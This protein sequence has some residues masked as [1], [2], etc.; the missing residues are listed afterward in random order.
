[1]R[2]AATGVAN[3]LRVVS[4]SGSR[5]TPAVLGGCHGVEY[6]LSSAMWPSVHTGSSCKNSA[7]AAAA[8]PAATPSHDRRL[9]SKSSSGKPTEA[10]DEAGSEPE[11]FL[12][13][14]ST[15]VNTL[16]SSE[17]SSP[18]MLTG[19][20]VKS[21]KGY[22]EREGM[23]RETQKAVREYYK[24]GMYQD[25]LEVTERLVDQVDDHFGRA[26]GV[27]G[28]ALSDM[29][30]MLKSVG[31]HQEATDTYL[32]AL[33]VYRAVYKGEENASFAS[34]LH[35]LGMLFRAMAEDSKKL[36]K[37]PLMERAAESFERCV[38][39]REKILTNN[40][41]DLQLARSRLAT[42]QGMLGGGEKEGTEARLR[43]ALD[44]LQMAVGNDDASTANAKT[45]LAFFLKGEGKL[46]EATEL[47]TDVLETRKKLFGR[48]HFDVLVSMHNLSMTHHVAGREDEAI[49]LRDEIAKIGEEMGMTPE[50]QSE[51]SGAAGGGVKLAQEEG[52]KA[53]E[54]K[55]DAESAWKP[56]HTRS[57]RKGNKR[58]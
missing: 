35:N 27:Y 48:K 5:A 39:I 31:R 19:P 52:K 13:V 44:G 23:I 40:H 15:P 14:E 8:V 11:K 3:C 12:E 50:E 46:A 33:E 1:M 2:R 30:L 20:R 54:K 41:P 57:R 28:S 6:G 9:S 36:E 47:Y 37:I 45:N 42:V 55:S 53:P 34:T 22:L 49:K 10:A 56:M 4:A 18:S 43:A 32:K 29:A 21:K 58:K 38:Q 51:A 17:G 16:V 7:T 25:A 26:H 24:E